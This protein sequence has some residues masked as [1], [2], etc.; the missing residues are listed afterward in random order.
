MP[1]FNRR[2]PQG[3][4]PMTGRGRGRCANRGNIP[5]EKNSGSAQ[6]PNPDAI[7]DDAAFGN[8][9]FGFGLGLKRGRWLGRGFRNRW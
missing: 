7:S 2:G 9:G 6:S 1:G 4:G 8:R 5:S 3:E